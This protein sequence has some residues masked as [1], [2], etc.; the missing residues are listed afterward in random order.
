MPTKH[1]RAQADKPLAT[2]VI[3]AD[4]LAAV[5]TVISGTAV[6]LH[7]VRIDCTNNPGEDVAVPFY[8]S[9][10]PN[11]GTTEPR[12]LLKGVK[13]QVIEYRFKHGYLFGAN[14]SLAVVKEAGGMGT[15]P[16]S[17]T[18]NILMLTTIT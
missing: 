14:M 6:T 11:V 15:T 2:D 8:A 12:M 16:P 10:S 5:E 18:V 1:S 3:T 17:G 4:A 13:G 9:G 7:K